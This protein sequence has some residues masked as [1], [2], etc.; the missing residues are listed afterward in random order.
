MIKRWL[1]MTRADNRPVAVS[2]RVVVL[3]VIAIALALLILGN[4]PPD[5]AWQ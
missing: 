4:V 1:E 3:V 5:P 2:T